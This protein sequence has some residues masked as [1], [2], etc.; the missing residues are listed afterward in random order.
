MTDRVYD[1]LLYGSYGYTGQLIA[2]EL[3]KTGLRVLLS[4]RDTT[5]LK[6]QSEATGF[7]NRVF[8]LSDSIVADGTLG[9]LLGEARVLLNCAGPFSATA[10]PMAQ[11]CIDA[12]THYLD[13]TGEYRVFEA[14]MGLDQQ[15]RERGVI[16]MP[17]VGFDVVPT[18][19]MARLL[20]EKMP[21]AS[22]LVLAFSSRPAGLSSGTAR[23]AL[24][25]AGDPPLVRRNGALVST[26]LP[27]PTREIDFGPFR[28]T[29]VCISWG[30]IATAYRTTGI[31]DIEVFLGVSP[32]QAMRMQ[33]MLKMG[34]LMRL[35]PVRWL[36]DLWIGRSKGPSETV[37]NEGKTF[38]YGA[39]YGNNGTCMEARMETPN[40]Y[41]LTAWAAAHI[42][43]KVLMLKND[44]GYHT[45]A[46]LFGSG[47]VA[48]MEGV[49]VSEVR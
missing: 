21:D 38:I 12:R 42:T 11:A 47:L 6:E 27:A 33:R 19:C 2:R 13:I 46:G 36:A 44:T 8:Q 43:Q 35:A 10:W 34:G 48:E 25:N 5:K 15:A 49:L 16:L 9:R 37:L 22:R 30:D 45:P 40:G 32:K 24:Q 29:G 1:V 17:G 31:R 4:G 7:P 18:D 23:T 26:G 41:R 14:L 3:K 28:S 20:R 39:I